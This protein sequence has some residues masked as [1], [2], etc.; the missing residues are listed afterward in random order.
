MQRHI[1]NSGSSDDR[2]TTSRWR[3]ALPLVVTAGVCGWTVFADD[4]VARNVEAAG[5]HSASLVDAAGTRIVNIVDAAVS[6]GEA[7]VALVTSA[8]AAASAI[9]E[10]LS[11]LAS[12]LG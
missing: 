3:S 11:R 1:R 7:A 4:S 12:V 9:V 8:A 5:G 10:A 6:T 2:P